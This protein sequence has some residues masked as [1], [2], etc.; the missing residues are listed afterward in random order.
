MA[1]KAIDQD[2]EQERCQIGPNFDITLKPILRM[3][4]KTLNPE[5]LQGKFSVS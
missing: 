4:F 5:N 2:S 3:K 1:Q